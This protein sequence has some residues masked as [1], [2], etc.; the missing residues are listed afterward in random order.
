MSLNRNLQT[1]V[2]SLIPAGVVASVGDPQIR[3]DH[4]W[5]PGELAMSNFVRLAETQAEAWQRVTGKPV[6]SDE[7]RGLASWFWRNVHFAHGEE[8]R[9]DFFDEGFEKSDWNREYWHGLFAHGFGL[10]GTTHAQWTAEFQTLL[11]HSRSRA[12]GVE[13]HNSFEIFLKGGAYGD[14][15]WALL[16]HDLSTVVFSEDGTRLV[17]IKE[18]IPAI[19]TLGNPDYLPGR[20]R[21]WPVAGLHRDDIKVFTAFQNAE[22]FAGYAGPPPMVHLRRGETFRRY[23]EPGLDDGKTFVFWGRNYNVDGIPGPERSR[24]WVNQPE[25]MFAAKSA[26]A[27][28]SGQV[29]YA[30]AVFIYRPDFSTAQYRE[31]VVDE[32]PGHVTF[33]FSSPYV[34]AATPPDDSDWGIYKSGCRNGLVLHSNTPVPARISTDRGATW[35][36]A[37]GADLTDLVKGHQQ[38]WLRF[39]TGAPEL[40]KAA[41]EIRTVCQANVA[42]LP[43]LEDGSNPIT[44]AASGKAVVSAGPNRDQALAH[45]VGGS[46]DSPGITLKLTAPRGEKVIGIHAASHNLSGNPPSPDV[47]YAIHC[48]HDGGETWIPI[49]KDWRILPRGINPPDFWSQSFTYGSASIE[50]I[51]APIL[52]RFSNDGG[53]HYRRVE[54]HLIYETGGSS[55]SKVT[56]AWTNGDASELR[57][58]SHVYP[59]A[60]TPDTSWHLDAGKDVRTRWVEIA[61]D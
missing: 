45:L 34:I 36:Q 20:Q 31:G 2:F 59:P 1:F 57:T 58:E 30:N 41:I 7:D 22:Y 54:A 13:G 5:Y 24:S 11:G 15:R 40:S 27:Y 29:R 14:G 60:P 48:S 55:A 52:V 50:P 4:D 17:S 21:G 43:H 25:K 8:G 3:T 12:V 32:S 33:E 56:F 9:G 39:D 18:L 53:K 6:S 47:R 26:A 51:A 16:D 49:T 61:A 19:N 37:D 28:R 10:C 42:T 23:L 46:L 44:F 38:Y 35:R